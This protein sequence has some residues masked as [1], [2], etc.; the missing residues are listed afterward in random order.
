MVL[1]KPLFTLKIKARIKTRY[2][3]MFVHIDMDLPQRGKL[4]INIIETHL[5]LRIKNM[6]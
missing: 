3:S 2:S 6:R 5:L 1:K 4:P